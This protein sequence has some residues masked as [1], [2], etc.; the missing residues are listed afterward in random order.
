MMIIRSPRNPVLIVKAP[1]LDPKPY[2]LSPKIRSLGYVGS[3]TYIGAEMMNCQGS[4]IRVDN[5]KEDLRFRV[6]L[7]G[8]YYDYMMTNC[9]TLQKL[10]RVQG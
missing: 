3:R 8:S 2:I 5:K 9:K 6:R 7:Q 4:G 1:T 10:L